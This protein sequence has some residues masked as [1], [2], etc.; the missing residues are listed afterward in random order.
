MLIDCLIRFGSSKRD[1]LYRGD[2]APGPGAYD[3][4]RNQRKGPKGGYEIKG[5]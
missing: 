3:V 5:F 1:D 4:L 2:Q